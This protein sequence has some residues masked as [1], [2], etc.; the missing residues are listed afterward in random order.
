[1]MEGSQQRCTSNNNWKKCSSYMVPKL[2]PQAAQ[3]CGC[4]GL[5][6]TCI[7]GC[8]NNNNPNVEQ[9]SKYSKGDEDT[10]NSGID[11]CHVLAKATGKEECNLEHH[12]KAFNEEAERPF[13]K[14]VKFALTVSGTLNHRP[15]CM[16]QVAIEPLLAQHR[17]KCSQQ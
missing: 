14:A 5:E 12:W 2:L 8:A 16:A 9:Y 1:M 13:L 11:G 4:R 7:G 17:N 3:S 15:T 10:C 6:W